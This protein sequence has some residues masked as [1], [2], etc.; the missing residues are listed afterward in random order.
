MSQPP[1]SPEQASSVTQ[2]A[3]QGEDW[4]QHLA[5]MQALPNSQARIQYAAKNIPGAAAA[6]DQARAPGFAERQAR[7][8]SLTQAIQ[9]HD[10]VAD[11]PG[12]NL[13]LGFQA[14]T[15]YRDLIYAMLAHSS[16]LTR[17]QIEGIISETNV[18]DG[19]QFDV[20][21]LCRRDRHGKITGLHVD[22]VITPHDHRDGN[23]RVL[24]SGIDLRAR[25]ATQDAL[26]K[27]NAI[28][29]RVYGKQLASPR[30]PMGDF[31]LAHAA[32]PP[33]ATLAQTNVV[34]G[35]ELDNYD[36]TFS[37][38]MEL[39]AKK[40]VYETLAS[41]SVDGTSSQLQ[42]VLV[43]FALLKIAED[44]GLMS[45][46][47]HH[48]G[49][50]SCAGVVLAGFQL[51]LNG[52]DPNLGHLPLDQV[53]GHFNNICSKR[54]WYKEEG[55][56]TEAFLDHASNLASEA[57][58]RCTQIQMQQ[59]LAEVFASDAI[60]KALDPTRASFKIQYMKFGEVP[61][62]ALAC[63]GYLLET[64]E[65]VLVQKKRSLDQAAAAGLT[66]IQWLEGN[67]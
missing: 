48:L 3:F 67:P 2:V 36:A 15:S 20:M 19:V 22:L 55:L 39:V 4:D 12:G 57:V 51:G 10:L 40:R 61:T 42:Q 49:I 65:A 59:L 56:L 14:I 30:N 31:E 62:K 9:C 41:F 43:V 53:V 34:I 7:I 38:K 64:K 27:T 60:S 28:I 5:A 33:N 26:A 1:A 13:G 50:N 46:I 24:T 66:G 29:E 21:L 17:T 8:L 44:S 47:G 23:R 58:T 18:H 37:G 52:Q 63:F 35:T 6:A 25:A 32:S 45:S 54:V 11:V 16:I